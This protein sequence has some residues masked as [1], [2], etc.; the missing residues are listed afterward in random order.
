M[1]VQSISARMIQEWRRSAR[2]LTY[3]YRLVPNA[4]DRFKGPCGEDD[5]NEML[6]LHDF[7]ELALGYVKTMIKMKQ[8][9]GR[10][11]PLHQRIDCC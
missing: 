10:I 9:R 2:I 1:H 3:H 7:D 8:D 4:M 11:I 6:K 5:V